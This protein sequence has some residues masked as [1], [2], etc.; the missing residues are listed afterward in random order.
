MSLLSLRRPGPAVVTLLLLAALLVVG[1]RWS[2]SRAESAPAAVPSTQAVGKITLTDVV[3]T[4]DV[5]TTIR[6]F[7]WSGQNAGD[8]ASGGGS[9]SGKL[10]ASDGTVGIDTAS[11]SPL[12]FNALATGRHLPTVTVV[13][14]APGTTTRREQW[15]FTDARVTRLDYARSGSQRAAPRASLAWGYTAV[16]WSTY[17]AN[18]TTVLQTHC[19]NLATST[20]CPAS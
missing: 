12:L 17:A 7:G 19:T 9:G 1:G 3:G 13:V 18:G 2:D 11:T 4:S 10:T 16:R 15:T 20:T 8:T 6:S 5:S 14:F